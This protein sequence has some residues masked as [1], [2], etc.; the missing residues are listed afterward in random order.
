MKI[1]IIPLNVGFVR[2]HTYEK[3]EV[4]VND[5]NH[6]TGKSH[7]SAHQ[8]CK[9]NLSLTKKIP[10]VFHNMIYILSFKKLENII[11]K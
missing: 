4:K 10:V 11:S 5:Q 3:G 6:I 8:E 9:S 2:K 1:L 7:G